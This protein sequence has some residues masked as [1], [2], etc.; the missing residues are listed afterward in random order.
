VNRGKLLLAGL[1]MLAGLGVLVLAVPS[2]DDPNP[3][4][5]PPPAPRLDSG[6]VFVAT[7]TD[8]IR[9]LVAAT[10]PGQQLEFVGVHGSARDG[11]RVNVRFAAA[12]DAASRRRAAI[13]RDMWEIYKALYTSRFARHIRSVRIEAR[14]SVADK[15]GSRDLAAALTTVLSRVKG[16]QA[17]WDVRAPPHPPVWMEVFAANGL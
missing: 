17:N 4:P 10:R 2:R 8:A 6:G 5:P 16:R 15:Y 1:G 9:N 13:E 3:P 11:Y 14:A 12:D 7:T